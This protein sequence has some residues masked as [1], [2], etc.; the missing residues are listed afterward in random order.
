MIA[1]LVITQPKSHQEWW[2]YYTPKPSFSNVIRSIL[3]ANANN[4]NFYVQTIIGD[5]IQDTQYFNVND[6][7]WIDI[8]DGIITKLIDAAAHYEFEPNANPQIKHFYR[9][10]QHDQA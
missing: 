8:F 1:G 10:G 5:T 6:P 7:D 4:G 9:R 3:A 2:C